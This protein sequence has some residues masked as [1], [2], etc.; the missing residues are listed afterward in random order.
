[1]HH[2]ILDS[3]MWNAEGIQMKGI[4]STSIKCPVSVLS[5]IHFLPQTLS[6]M[7]LEAAVPILVMQECRLVVLP[8]GSVPCT[9]G[10]LRSGFY[11]GKKTPKSNAGH[12]GPNLW[13]F[14]LLSKSRGDEIQGTT[15]GTAH[16]YC[17]VMLCPTRDKSLG[18]LT[19]PQVPILLLYRGFCHLLLRVHHLTLPKHRTEIFAD[20]VCLCI[21]ISSIFLSYPATDWY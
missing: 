6:W 17:Q 5:D 1:M 8:V 7:L 21:S 16:F 3:A 15:S 18:H 9:G 11:V 2:C 4:K 12:P 14:Y 20:H 10:R 19:L 13:S